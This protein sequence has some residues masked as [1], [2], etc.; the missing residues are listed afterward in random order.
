MR[1]IYKKVES[2]SAVNVY[3]TKQEIED[4]KLTRDRIEDDGINPYQNEVLIIYIGKI[5]RQHRWNIGQ[6]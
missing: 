4:N 5:S 6:Y 2:D 3:T 1:H